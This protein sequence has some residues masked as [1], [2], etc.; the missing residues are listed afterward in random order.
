MEDAMT[1]R[2]VR[3][4]LIHDRRL[5]VFGRYPFNYMP[6]LS[7]LWPEYCFNHILETEKNKRKSAENGPG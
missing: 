4:K 5:P 3:A 7:L 1:R 2:S 6:L